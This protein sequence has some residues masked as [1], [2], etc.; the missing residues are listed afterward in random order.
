MSIFET[1]QYEWRETYFVLFDAKNLPTAAAVEEQLTSLPGRFKLTNIVSSEDGK[2]E[3]A[4]LESPADFAAL[5]ISLVIGDEVEEYSL[6]M[7]DEMLPA[8]E[9]DAERETIKKIPLCDARLD[10]MHFERVDAEGQPAGD[11][12]IDPM[13]DPSALLVVLETLTEILDGIGV[14]PQTSCLL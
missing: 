4:T 7:V 11:D 13:F 10:V 2:F 3:G 9:S 8:A 12:E 5:D 6:Q 14:D 1:D